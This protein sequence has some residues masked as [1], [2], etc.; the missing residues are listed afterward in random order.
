MAVARM[1]VSAANVEQLVYGG[2]DD[3]VGVLRGTE[4]GKKNDFGPWAL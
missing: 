3:S 2:A 4:T 1:R